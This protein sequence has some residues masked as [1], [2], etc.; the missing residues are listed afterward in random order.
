MYSLP[1][2]SRGSQALRAIKGTQGEKGRKVGVSQSTISLYESDSRSPK[3]RNREKMEAAWE[4]PR[5][6]WDEPARPVA[7]AAAVAAPPG[8]AP[9][10]QAA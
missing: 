10:A 6:W 8:L 3:R 1:F 2:R 5:G 7:L 4:I 9:L